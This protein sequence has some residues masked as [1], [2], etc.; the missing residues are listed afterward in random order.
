[1]VV[2]PFFGLKE[3]AMVDLIIAGMVV[4]SFGVLAFGGFC[5]SM[6]NK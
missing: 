3:F 2:S 1:M 4:G 6:A 5:I